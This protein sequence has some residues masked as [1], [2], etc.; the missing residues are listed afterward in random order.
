VLEKEDT[1]CTDKCVMLVTIT[2]PPIPLENN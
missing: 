2:G 1:F